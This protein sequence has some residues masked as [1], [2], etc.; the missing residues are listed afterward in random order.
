M[1]ETPVIEDVEAPPAFRKP[2]S[3]ASKKPTPFER[4]SKPREPKP[5][6]EAPVDIPYPKGGFKETLE[7]WYTGIGMAV[8]PLDEEIGTAII[9]CA[10]D[11]AEK[12]DKLAKQNATFRRI[13]AKMLE[14][15]LAM[16]IVVAHI[17]IILAVVS[18][19]MKRQG[20]NTDNAPT[21]LTDVISLALHRQRKE[22]EERDEQ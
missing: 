12:L 3:N 7:L 19:V 15:S 5:M 1:T 16:E 6:R 17:P 4:L 22:Q 20:K 14:T 2:N 10:S 18:A 11:C 9:E 13:L 8:L 21:N